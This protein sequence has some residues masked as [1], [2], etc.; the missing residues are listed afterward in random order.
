MAEYDLFEL[1]RARAASFGLAAERIPGE[2]AVNTGLK[3]RI[4]GKRCHV[5]GCNRI[6]AGT[7]NTRVKPRALAV[8]MRGS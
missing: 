1:V 2:R 6:C 5:R 7:A 8:L 4:N 3:V